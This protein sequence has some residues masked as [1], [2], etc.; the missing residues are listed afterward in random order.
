MKR[1][2]KKNDAV[3]LQI[4]LAELQNRLELL[5]KNYKNSIKSVSFLLHTDHNF[6]LPPYEE[7]TEDEYEK[8]V[9]KIDFSIPMVAV[10][11]DAIEFDDCNSGACPVK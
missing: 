11:S 1:Q 7:I 5:Q 6:A 8:S 10:A 9:R 3:D 4:Q 2:R